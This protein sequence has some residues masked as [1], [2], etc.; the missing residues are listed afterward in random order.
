M[1]KIAKSL[2]V[3]WRV[4]G[5][6]SELHSSDSAAAGRSVSRLRHE[7]LSTA[8]SDVQSGPGKNFCSLK[9]PLRR[10]VADLYNLLSIRCSLSVSGGCAAQLCCATNPLQIE[11]GGVWVFEMIPARFFWAQVAVSNEVKRELI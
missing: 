5:G 10:L 4:V 1:F 9:T 7:R 3:V 2:S 6:M 8:L 11:V